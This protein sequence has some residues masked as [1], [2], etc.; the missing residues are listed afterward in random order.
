MKK[1]ILITVVIVLVVG[2]GA[3]YGGMKYGQNKISTGNLGAAGFSNLTTEQR[4]ALR[5]QQGNAN[6]QGGTMRANGNMTAGEIIAR[7]DKTITIKMP[8]GGSKIVFYSDST[9]VQK[10]T[11]G[12]SADLQIGQ[13]VT[14]NGTANSDGSVT[15]QTIQIRPVASAPNQNN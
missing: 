12:T 9:T 3:F 7:D 6:F 13:E 10:S 15:A 2:A 14:T 4:Q 5:Q 11:D 8:D 1:N